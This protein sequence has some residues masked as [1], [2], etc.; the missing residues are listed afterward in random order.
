[1]IRLLFLVTAAISVYGAYYY[2]S[3]SALPSSPVHTAEPI[4]AEDSDNYAFSTNQHD[5]F[6]A[7]EELQDVHSDHDHDHDHSNNESHS[8][9][10]PDHDIEAH[11]HPNHSHKPMNWEP[12]PIIRKPIDRDFGAVDTSYHP[13]HASP[14]SYNTTI[15]PNDRNTLPLPPPSPLS[16]RIPSPLSNRGPSPQQQHYDTIHSNESHFIG[17]GGGGGG[18]M[19]HQQPP[20]PLSAG[21]TPSPGYEAHIL[22]LRNNSFTN[23]PRFAPQVLQAGRVG[24][25]DPFRDDAGGDGNGGGQISFPEGAYG[26]VGVFDRDMR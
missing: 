21:R 5:K 10:H 9:I 2:R 24:G 6:I 17:G 16:H 19:H 15:R 3:H 14:P 22:P 8:P 11:P 7:P 4:D 12:E 26:R 18:L 13:S 20:S 1:M 25:V 23:D